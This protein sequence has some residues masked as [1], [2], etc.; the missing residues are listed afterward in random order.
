MDGGGLE[1]YIEIGRDVGFGD[2]ERLVVGAGG[3][4][5]V[6]A[7]HHGRESKLAMLIGGRGLTCPRN[8]DPETA[9]GETI[10]AEQLT[11]ER[12]CRAL[13]QYD[14]K[15]SLAARPGGIA[16]VG[17]QAGEGLGRFEAALDLGGADF[18]KIVG[19]EQHF[20]LRLLGEGE[21][22]GIGLLGGHGEDHGL[23]PQ[24]T[25]GVDRRD[26]QQ[27]GS[28]VG[29]G[30]GGAHVG[31]RGEGP[32]GPANVTPGQGSERRLTR[33]TPLASRSTRMDWKRATELKNPSRSSRA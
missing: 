9:G 2:L 10:G 4:Q 33:R 21:Q 12:A 28:E 20:D 30:E 27:D 14:D 11:A 26:Q 18:V 24:R 29:D 1:G 31:R 32:V 22:C 6:I 7:G 17:E 23:G 8:R 19:G 15:L 5:M 25:A 3:D 16:G 13:G